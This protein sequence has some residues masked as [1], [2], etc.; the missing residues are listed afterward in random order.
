MVADGALFSCGMMRGWRGSGSVSMGLTQRARGPVG[1]K[2][3]KRC[4]PSCLG[5]AVD[6][7][8]GGEP[9]ES[10][11]RTVAAMALELG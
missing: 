10:L 8:Q 3:G 9:S 4:A 5:M 11:A 2:L 6:G 7:E 1:G